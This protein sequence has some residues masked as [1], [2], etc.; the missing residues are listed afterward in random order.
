MLARRQER[1]WNSTRYILAGLFNATSGQP[2]PGLPDTPS[3]GPGGAVVV[4]DLADLDALL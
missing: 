4:N 1:G 3:Q 2:W